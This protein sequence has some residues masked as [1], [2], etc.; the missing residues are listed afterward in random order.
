MSDFTFEMDIHVEGIILEK[1]TGVFDFD[2]WRAERQKVL[3]TR[4]CGVNLI[5]RP[6]IVDVTVS[7]PPPEAWKTTFLSIHN[8]LTQVDEGTGPIALVIGDNP[9]KYMTARLFSEIIDVY[10]GSALEI[11]PYRTF[12]DAFHWMMENDSWRDELIN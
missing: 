3:D 9:M 10:R 2:V 12:D 4:L 6:S 1:M 7:D 5:G 8:E 11:T